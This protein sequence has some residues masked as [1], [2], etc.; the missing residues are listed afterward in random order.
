MYMYILYKS[1]YVHIHEQHMLIKIKI[2]LSTPS[3]YPYIK[4]FSSYLIKLGA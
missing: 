4:N 3:V 2:V 1:I